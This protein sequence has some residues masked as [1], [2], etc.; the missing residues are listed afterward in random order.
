MELAACA[1]LTASC[2]ILFSVAISSSARL[3]QIG[4]MNLL[5]ESLTKLPFVMAVGTSMKRWEKN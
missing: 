3:E 4:V 1:S 5:I 2:T